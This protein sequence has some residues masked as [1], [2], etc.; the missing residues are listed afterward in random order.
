MKTGKKNEK[1]ETEKNNKILDESLKDHTYVGLLL[2]NLSLQ[3]LF[4]KVKNA[5]HF[6]M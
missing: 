6:A 1:T 2:C 4:E 3:L 5:C